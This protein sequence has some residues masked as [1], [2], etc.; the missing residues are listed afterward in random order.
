MQLQK[1]ALAMV[2]REGNGIWSCCSLAQLAAAAAATVLVKV[3][4]LPPAV[5]ILPDPTPHVEAGAASSTP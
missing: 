5:S 1:Q 2:M 4:H 3:P